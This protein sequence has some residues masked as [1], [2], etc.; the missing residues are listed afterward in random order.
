[1]VPAAIGIG[2]S[3]DPVAGGGVVHVAGTGVGRMGDQRPHLP[4][5]SAAGLRLHVFEWREKR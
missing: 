1:M 4:D 2:E 5:A 3:L